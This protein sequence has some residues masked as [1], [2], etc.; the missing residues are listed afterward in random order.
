M[1][2][3]TVSTIVLALLVAVLAGCQSLG[4]AQPQAPMENYP[5]HFA[6]GAISIDGRLDEP[7]WGHAEAIAKFYPYQP[8]DAQQ[9]SPTSARLLWDDDHLYLAFECEDED[10]WSYSDKADDEL[11]NGD[12]VEFFVKPSTE[13]PLYYE[14]VMAPSGALYDGQYPSRGAGGYNRFKGWSSN[15]KVGTAIA[16]TAD[17]WS[18]ADQGYVVELAIPRAAFPEALQPAEGRTWTFSVFR[19]DYSK[20]YDEPLLMMAIPAAPAW[21]FHYYEGYRP[22]VFV[23]P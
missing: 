19:Y 16:G 22:L 17:D 14:F 11:W 9:L 8:E 1:S 10:I 18:D 5:C 20:A 6:G 4:P 2:R 13:Q 3:G 21:G 23:K 12:V 7:A 15:A